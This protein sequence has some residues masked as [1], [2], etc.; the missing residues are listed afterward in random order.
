MAEDNTGEKPE[1]RYVM[2]KEKLDPE[3][4]EAGGRSGQKLYSCWNDGA[5]NYFN[6]SWSGYTCWR[7]GAHNDY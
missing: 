4:S 2:G 7:C 3:T 6:G 1:K 5:L